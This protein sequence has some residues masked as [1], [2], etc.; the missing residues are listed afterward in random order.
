MLD[1]QDDVDR[2]F[3]TVAK[4]KPRLLVLDPLVRVH[5]SN[6]NDAG[7]IAAILGQLRLLQRTHNAAVV[8]VHHSRKNGRGIPGQDLRGSGDLHAWGDSNAYLGRRKDRLV[9]TLEQRFHRPIDPL[10]L[11]I[12]ARPDDSCPHLVLAD[13]QDTPP[14]PQ[15]ALHQAIVDALAAESTPVPRTRLRARLHLNNQRLGAALDE[16]QRL[17]RARKTKQG[18]ALDSSAPAQAPLFR[19]GP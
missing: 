18:W 1:R 3:S 19:S 12:Q 16:L 7:E 14:T 4:H 8:L 10:A 2:L 6:E 17:G 11:R 9:L 15:P 5:T 13:P